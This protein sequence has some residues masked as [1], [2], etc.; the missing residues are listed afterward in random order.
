MGNILQL[1]ICIG[2]GFIL[3]TIGVYISCRVYVRPLGAGLVN[4]HLVKY[5]FV[6][7]K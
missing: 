4:V 7:D 5:I 6:L 2:I 3:P 1:D